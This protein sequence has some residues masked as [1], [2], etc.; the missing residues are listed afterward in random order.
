MLIIKQPSAGIVEKSYVNWKVWKLIFFV[1]FKKKPKKNVK[2]ISAQTSPACSRRLMG[3]HIFLS[4]LK[5]RGKIPTSQF[6]NGYVE[7]FAE[8]HK[9]FG[10]P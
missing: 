1:H 2:G 5:E 8:P 4:Q 3:L 6:K 10:T 9:F 7:I